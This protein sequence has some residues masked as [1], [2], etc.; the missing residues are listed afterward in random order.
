MGLIQ[1]ERFRLS[2]AV[3]T[4]GKGAFWAG[5]ASAKT[6]DGAVGLGE[7]L[8]LYVHVRVSCVCKGTCRRQTC[9]S[10]KSQAKFT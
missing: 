2:A 7:Q 9:E 1:P 5:L 10:D 8:T 3:K 6:G 4:T